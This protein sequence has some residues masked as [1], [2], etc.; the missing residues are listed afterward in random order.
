MACN[1]YNV[2]RQSVGME[3]VFS[4]PRTINIRCHTSEGESVARDV[5]KETYH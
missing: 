2:G 1:I 5:I 4:D 3:L